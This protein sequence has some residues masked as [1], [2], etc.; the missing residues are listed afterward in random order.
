MKCTD[1][2][3]VD[4]FLYINTTPDG[5]LFGSGDPDELD[6]T[7]YIESANLSERHA[8]IKFVDNCKYLLRDCDSE[9][10]TWIRVGHPGEISLS[11]SGSDT[12]SGSDLYLENRQRMFK[13]GDYQFIFEEH[14]SLIFDDVGCWL[15]SNGFF[16]LVAMF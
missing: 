13:A 15:K 6:L 3:F 5:E 4:K 10:G 8:E 9:T 1:G 16:D 2:I 14:P 12:S 11:S 7:M